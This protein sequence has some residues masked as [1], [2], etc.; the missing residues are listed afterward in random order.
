M[1]FYLPENLDLDSLIRNN[2]PNFRPFKRDKLRYF[3]HIINAIPLLNKDKLYD[4]YT[5]INA[6]VI[7]TVI[8]N[9]KQYISYAI[10][11]LQI[12]ECDNH[13]IP[14]E[15]SL[16]YKFIDKYQSDLVSVDVKEFTLRKCLRVAKNRREAS[17][18]DLSFL[19]KFFD[20]SKLKID[21]EK[22]NEFLETER[23]LKLLHSHL[24]DRDFKTQKPKDPQTQYN[25]SKMSAERLSQGQYHLNRDD[26]VYRFHSNLTNMRSMIRNA[27]TYDGQ[28]LIAVD[29]K[30][31][32]PYLSTILLTSNFWAI[33]KNEARLNLPQS[34]SFYKPNESYKSFSNREI[35]ISN[36]DISKRDSYIMIGE[37]P[38]LLI[39][40]EFSSY[41]NLVVRGQLY[42][43]LQ[44]HF[45]M[46]TG[47]NFVERKEVKK[48]VFQ[49]LFTDNRYIGQETAKPKRLFKALFPEVYEVFSAIKREDKTLLPRLLQSIESYL[50]VNIIAKRISIEYPDAPIFTIH[51]SITTTDEYI[52]VVERIMTEE[53]TKA[54]G[55]APTLDRQHWD[56]TYMD[57]YIESLHERVR[58]VA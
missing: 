15:K 18:K 1:N 38:Q 12:V 11:D 34:L 6:K 52:D 23:N 17:V 14:G 10:E 51:D 31:S 19:T 33:E 16:G 40:R 37:I 30:N 49:V 13:Y 20:A 46:E 45:Q 44:S 58:K 32:Q 57:K 24:V 47:L 54:I 48:A 43:F 50:I 5:Y 22:V 28:K 26:N 4:E 8:Q 21:L 25:H 42:E 53:L 41:I 35:S 56:T 39:D 36:I 27:I 55:Y 29:I 3:L 9:Y 2:P 7:Q